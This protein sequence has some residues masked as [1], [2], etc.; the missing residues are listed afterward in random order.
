[1]VSAAIAAIALSA[2]GPSARAADTVLLGG[3]GS[4]AQRFATDTPTMTLKRLPQDDASFEK[5]HW[6]YYRPWV[7]PW[8]VGYYR[9]WIR[10]WYGY[11]WY[12]PWGGYRP[13][14]G[15]GFYRPWVYPWLGWSYPWYGIS[16]TYAPAVP[17]DYG[18]VETVPASLTVTQRAPAAPPAWAA[19]GSE[20]LPSPGQ[21][22]NFR[23]DGGP[24]RPVPP[25]GATPP[26]VDEPSGGR[27]APTRLVSQ[28][29]P[30]RAYPAYGE[31]PA[32]PVGRTT[33]VPVTEARR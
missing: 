13:G 22:G 29:K 9:P 32:K 26:P 19:P 31:P 27:G 8:G 16:Y 6:G 2:T 1:M 20:S 4:T 14:I 21:P 30:K 18:Y 7:R 11:G 15:Y 3:V 17:L 28:P 25:A 5:A 23:Y 12:R 33:N 10:P 24:V